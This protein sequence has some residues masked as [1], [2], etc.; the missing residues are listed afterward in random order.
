MTP[1]EASGIRWYR[2]FR[3]NLSVRSSVAEV[4]ARTSSRIVQH[5]ILDLSAQVSFYFVLSLL[6][7]LIVLAAVVGWLPSTTLWESF[8]Q[9]ITSYFPGRSRESVLRTILDLTRGYVGFL[10]FGLLTAVWSASS[11][12]MSLMEALSIACCGKETRPYWKRRATATFVTM[13]ASVFCL[14]AFG[15]WTTGHWAS[16]VFFEEITYSLPTRSLWR[17]AAWYLGTITLMFVALS[18]AHRFL[19]VCRRSW[20]WF[21]PGNIFTVVSIVLISIG[22]NVFL[23]YSPTVPRVYSVLAGFVLLMTWIYMAN[24]V[25]LAGAELDTALL[26]L[27][28]PQ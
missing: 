19:P 3:R 10:S 28:D 24:L 18:L 27:Q 5:R 17:T 22:F 21:S 11:G 12:F 8:A 6:P 2:F 9:W 25:L 13:V 16:Q 14:L 7:F 15:L 20:R 23:R 26:D 1:A 4:I